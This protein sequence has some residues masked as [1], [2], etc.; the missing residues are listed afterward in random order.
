MFAALG[1][2][3]IGSGSHFGQ[4]YFSSF[5]WCDYQVDEPLD[6]QDGWT[7]LVSPN[8]AEV[9]DGRS[10]A[11]LGRRAVACW[12]GGD[13]E[14]VGGGLLD[15][16][17]EQVIDFDPITNPAIVRV[18]ASVRLDGPDTGSGPN[19]DLASANLYARNGAGRS[20]FFYLSSNGNAY[21]F[22]NS[23]SGSQGYKFET[24]IRLGAY[25]HLAITLD[26][27]TH[28]A[29]FEV[30][31]VT[32]GSL[33]FGGDG[34]KFRGVLLEFAAYEPLLDVELYT[35]Y[36]DNVSVRAKKAR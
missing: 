30:N 33:P 15:G 17:W 8:A 34:E 14:D 35:G 1:S 11:A 10:T 28:V 31:W 7:A 4:L 24:P 21:A 36:W 20:A 9:V 18:E 3:L 27:L 32:V 19:D 23:S 25:N 13:L 16:A 6:G 5:E 22:A 29:T 12:G 2:L 26:Y